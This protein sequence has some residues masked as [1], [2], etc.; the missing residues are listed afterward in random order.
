VVE[1]RLARPDELKVLFEIDDDS[2]KLYRSA[3]VIIDLPVA[4]PFIAD[5]RRRWAESVSA[6]RTLFAL[7]ESG[8]AV[9]FAAVDVLD[10]AAYLDQLSVRMRAMRRGVGKRLVR[11][12]C[13]LGEKLGNEAIW[14]TTYGH[15][16]WN[17]PFYERMGFVT[18]PEAEWS[19]GVLHHVEAQREALPLPEERVAM[20]ARLPIAGT[21]S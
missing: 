13:A 11:E 7:D 21:E 5:E 14:L 19:P 20:R 15:L 10:G 17:R 8:D 18:M 2:G 12:A 6:G 1:V 3:G 4:H 9:G 16:P